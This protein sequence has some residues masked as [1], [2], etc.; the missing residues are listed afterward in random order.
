[1]NLSHTS[2]AKILHDKVSTDIV[3][4]NAVYK[5][6]CN[7]VNSP[8]F[9]LLK[10]YLDDLHLHD[11]VFLEAQ[12]GPNTQF[13]WCVRD[14]GT[15]IVRLGVHPKHDEWMRAVIDQ[16]ISQQEFF[17]IVV[18]LSVEDVKVT[19]IT[20]DQAK[21]SLGKYAYTVINNWVLH[22]GNP[23][24]ELYIHTR[25]NE[26][27]QLGADVK[28]VS[29]QVLSQI[30]IGAILLIA[31]NEVVVATGSLFTSIFSMTLNEVPWEELQAVI[32]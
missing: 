1:M 16:N 19:K 30:H 23:I 14:S 32:A 21:A 27:H 22:K 28:V 7:I 15:Y 8:G 9:G 2:N 31:Q 10:H 29:K 24:A 6:L 20:Q 25:R 3:T 13:I 18:G 11:R 26:Q 4:T 12:A 5:A 17:R